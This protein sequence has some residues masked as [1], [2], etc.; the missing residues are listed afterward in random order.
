MELRKTIKLTPNGLTRTKEAMLGQE[1]DAWL[2][3]LRYGDSADVSLYSATKQQAT[4]LRHRLK[5]R[6]SM[7]RNYPMILR[8]DVIKLEKAR[9]A[10]W[11]RWWFRVPVAAIRGGLW[12]PVTMA[13]AHEELLVDASIKVCE[14]KLIRK[15]NH[16]SVHVV[17]QKD[18]QAPDI[19]AYPNIL[20]IDMGERNPATAVLMAPG[21][22]VKPVFYGREVKGI[23][24]HH[25]WL[26]TALQEKQAFRTMKKVKDRESRR[27]AALLHRAAKDIVASA[28]EASATIVIGDFT[29]GHR[30]TGKGRRFNRIVSSMPFHSLMSMIEYKA[31]WQGVPVVC[32]GEAYTSQECHVCHAMGKRR[33]QSSFECDACGWR[34]NADMNGALNIGQRWER[35]QLLVGW[36]GA[37]STRPVKPAV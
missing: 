28:K 9:N 27:V 22:S 25:A 14:A 32:V 19:D 10:E 4:I 7:T 12:C 1:Y 6:F 31:M 11:S 36:S 18:V 2:A 3:C 20:A 21:S 33:T 26:R 16:W 24:R 30:N 34:G 17:L 8:N 5:K 37:G 13:P 29:G 35:L 23:R 15:R